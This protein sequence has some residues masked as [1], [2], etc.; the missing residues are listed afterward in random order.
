MNKPLRIYLDNC[1]FNRPFDDQTQIRIRLETEAKLFI[2]EKIHN[3]EMELVWS[4][5]VNL[6][7]LDNPFEF[8][9]KSIHTWKPVSVLQI[10]ENS[11]ILNKAKELKEKGVKIK[12]SLHIA[13]AIE[14]LC[15]YFFTT[16]DNLIKK[17]KESAE[18]KV[19]NPIEYVQKEQT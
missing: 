13:C 17:M 19:L 15:D 3:K 10:E 2:Q 6:E 12:D 4:Y 7:N 9:K 18:I 14:G 16:D 11:N 5:I 8:R 1:C